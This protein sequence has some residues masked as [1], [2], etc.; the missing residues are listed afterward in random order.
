MMD[1]LATLPLTAK[2]II[3]V[4]MVLALIGVLTIGKKS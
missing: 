4:V 3:T 1:W 2:V